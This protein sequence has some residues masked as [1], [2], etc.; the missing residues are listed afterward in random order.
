MV[1]TPKE[2]GILSF[3]YGNLANVIS[4]IPSQAINFAFKDKYKQIFL[5]AVHE[6]TQFWCFFA[7]NLA[8]GGATGATSLCFIYTLDFSH[9]HLAADIGKA[10]SE[11]EFKDLNDCFIEV[12]RSG[13]IRG[14]YQGFNV[15]VQ[16]IIIYRAAYFNI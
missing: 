7:G 6:R 3:W 4:Y 16:G 1:C 11:R 13:W 9:T 8:S 5:G 12:Y 15:S 2:K 14:L 10:A